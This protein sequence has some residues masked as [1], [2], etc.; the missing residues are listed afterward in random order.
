MVGTKTTKTVT[1]EKR[2]TFHDDAFFKDSWDEW[3][4]AMKDVVER[5]DHG[6]S[7][8]TSTTTTSVVPGGATG[9]ET[10]TV[11]RQI[12][13]SNVSSD[14]SQA[15]SCKEEDDKYK[16][17]VDVKDFSPEDINVKTVDDTV[18]VEGKIEKKE[19]NAVSTQRFT[20]R[21]MLPSGVDLNAIS[22]ALS[23]DGVL[24]INAP[25]LAIDSKNQSRSVHV[26]RYESLP[27]AGV[28]TSRATPTTHTTNG[29]T[30]F[31]SFPPELHRESVTVRKPDRKHIDPSLLP[32]A[33]KPSDGAATTTTV[34]THHQPQDGH[35]S[36]FNKMV[37]KSQREMEDMMRRHSL[38]GSE[39][40]AAPPS[41]GV[42]ATTP[43]NNATTTRDVVT[44]GNTTTEREEKRWADIPEPGIQRKNRSLNENSVIKGADGSVIGNEMRREKESHAAGGSEEMLPDGTKRKTFTK[45][46]ETRQVYSSFSG[47][48]A[49]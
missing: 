21:F 39:R 24:T 22:S 40:D 36:S 45:S 23:R 20:R 38:H 48:K 17:V 7:R 41:R 47:D 9:S 28:P 35:W 13:S 3:D 49:V 37:E 16:I 1:V 15:V 34:Q 18:V 27:A 30:A 8:P 32:P 31:K 6:T 5:W 12:R 44:K 4:K 25:K 33:G 19:G 14:D 26:T 11:Y 43:N 29:Q 10:K 2:G 42:V 46:Y